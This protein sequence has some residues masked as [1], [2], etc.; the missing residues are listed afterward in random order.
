MPV[1]GEPVFVRSGVATEATPQ[2]WVPDS[3][4]DQLRQ[5]FEAIARYSGGGRMISKRIANNQRVATLRRAFPDA[6]FVHLVR[7]GRAVAVSLTKVDWWPNSLVG[8]YGGTPKEWA[9]AGGHPMEI[10]AREWVDQVEA[11]EDGLDSVEP[12]R[13]LV[14]KYETFV[15]RP[16]PVLDE[17]ARFAGLPGD[18]GWLTTVSSL[19][20]PNRTNVSVTGLDGPTCALIESFQAPVL[21]R[22][23][24]EL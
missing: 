8:W 11:V 14:V 13:T 6:T 7:D 1:E 20:Y 16:L 9:Q 21:R 15:S 17:I 4:I 12:T 19:R 22:Y 3:A 18:A 24:Y 23:G 2:A 10:A 5:S